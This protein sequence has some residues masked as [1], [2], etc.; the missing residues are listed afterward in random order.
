MEHQPRSAGACFPRHLTLKRR[1]QFEKVRRE[2]KRLSG[3]FFHVNLLEIE[4]PAG[5]RVGIVVTRRFGNAVRRNRVRRRIRE[6][7]GKILPHLKPDHWLVV[8][9]RRE[10]DGAAF[11]DLETE[12][13]RL[14]HRT[15]VID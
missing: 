2:G 13:E 3:R 10:A 5:V 1:W 7:V 11:S 6:L 8:V 15:S 9:A 4:E 14:L 12:W